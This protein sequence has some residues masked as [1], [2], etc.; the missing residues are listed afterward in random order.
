MIHYSCKYAPIELFAA[1]GEEAALLDSEE[2]NFERAESLTHAN[3]C[4]H[5]KSL[6][7]QSLDKSDVIIMDC[8]D[9]LRRV[10]DVL[11]FEGAQDHLY[12]LD[13][14]HEDNGCARELF[15]GA[16]LKLARDL[17]RTTARTF[18]RARFCAA[19]EEASWD[20]PQEDFI[21]LLGGRVSPELQTSIEQE[22]ALP[23]ANVTCCGCRGLE[24]LPE[25]AATLS[26]EALMEWYAT[27]LLRMVPCM[28]MTDVSGRRVLFENPHLKGIIYNT[29]KFCDFYSFDYAAL[30]DETTLPMLKIESDY[31]PMA[32][33]QLSTRIE[34]FSESLGLERNSQTTEKVFNMQ[35]KY[36]AGIDSGSTTTNMVVLDREGTLVASAIVR[37]G[38]KA[39]RGAREALD[40]VCEQLDATEDDFAAIMATGY[41]RDNIPFATD[42][43]TEIS[44]HAHGAHHLNPA[45]RT[46]V[47]IGGQDSKV[48]CLDEAGEVS[49]F[50]MNDKCAAGTGRFLEMM[51]R[52]LELDMDQMSTRGLDWKRDL[53][54]SSMCSVF[55]ESEV[56]S[57]IADNHSDNDIV[58][59]LNKSIASKTASMVKRARGSAPFMMTGGVA[60]NVGVVQELESRLGDSLFITESP[61]LCGALGAARYAWEEQ[62]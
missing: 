7:Q 36:F 60:R 26:L 25:D 8:C 40:A 13:L 52:S 19:C 28:R 50:I 22:M 59:G 11:D 45:I 12:L 14:P 9:S 49:N 20:F 21:V 3:L 62:K 37:T 6:I 53:T 4:C 15:A 31:M 48:I 24:P 44:C 32:Q 23:V 34:A 51:A 57:L 54:I 29:V 41:G 58:H 18:D 39:E 35:G 17:A 33:G 27:A 42:T 38:P 61:D 47:D 43:K 10:Y 2:Q 56:I 5:A 1:F 46:I 55:A 30:K 16:L